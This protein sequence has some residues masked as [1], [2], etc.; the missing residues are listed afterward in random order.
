MFTNIVMV[1]VSE[2]DMGHFYL[3]TQAH[4][5]ESGAKY[6]TLHVIISIFNN[7]SVLRKRQSILFLSSQSANSGL[8]NLFINSV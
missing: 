7:T 1:F 6:Q 5:R 4:V 8:Q 3:Q 2:H